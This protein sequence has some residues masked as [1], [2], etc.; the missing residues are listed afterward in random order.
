M[1]RHVENAR[2][3]VAFLAGHDAVSSVLWPEL[4]SHPDHELSKHLLPKGPGAIF[5]FELKGGRE[6]G[7]KFIEA[8]QLFSHLANVRDAKSLVIHP[9]STTH[10]QMD[11]AALEAAGISE[12]LVRLFVGLEGSEH[13]DPPHRNRYRSRDFRSLRQTEP[14][15]AS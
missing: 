6:A 2:A 11:E 14:M 12:G 1:T 5:S 10:Q 4:R 7:A 3:I 8:L 13:H 9:V 15:P